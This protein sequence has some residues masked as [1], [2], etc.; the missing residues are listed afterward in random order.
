M[1][2]KKR[3]RVDGTAVE[4]I[5]DDDGDESDQDFALLTCPHTAQDASFHL[6]A[7]R[8]AIFESWPFMLESMLQF[9]AHYQH[10]NV[11]ESFSI[12]LPSG[13]SLQLGKWLA[14]VL[15]LYE[16]DLL[17]PKQKRQIEVSLLEIF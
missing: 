5:D 7:S 17:N 14:D 8:S 3:C 16:M 10:F 15:K 6:E 11:P 12:Q 4:S 2:V 1:S 13:G 9:G